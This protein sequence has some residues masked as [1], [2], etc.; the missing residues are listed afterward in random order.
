LR[1]SAS[2][3]P[4]LTVGT[5]AFRGELGVDATDPDVAFTIAIADSVEV[6]DGISNG[7][8]LRGPAVELVEALSVRAPLPA[9]TP[10]QW[11]TLLTTGL[12]AVFRRL[13]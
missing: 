7:P 3:G 11:R 13:T 12:A 1:Y 9:D 6:R 2:I 4:A 8:C 10:E 5:T